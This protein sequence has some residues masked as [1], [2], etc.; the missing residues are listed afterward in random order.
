[1]KADIY[2]DLRMQSGMFR[3]QLIEMLERYC[4]YVID[5]ET[6]Y[7]MI[8]RDSLKKM[9]LSYFPQVETVFMDILG[10]DDSVM[11]GFRNFKKTYDL[12]LPFT[13][14]KIDI[15][16]SLGSFEQNYMDYVTRFERV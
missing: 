16:D 15:E 5:G 8:V 3:L 14:K 6:A 1:M 2:L 11:V 10:C 7:I 12:L 13:E 9:G 4:F